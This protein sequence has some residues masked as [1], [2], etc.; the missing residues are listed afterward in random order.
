MNFLRSLQL[1]GSAGSSDG[2]GIRM[3]CEQCIGRGES[4]AE[5]S[6]QRERDVHVHRERA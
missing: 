2:W 6:S 1:S 3:V 4:S 5:V